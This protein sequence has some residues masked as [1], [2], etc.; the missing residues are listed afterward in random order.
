MY[1]TYVEEIA[2]PLSLIH[3]RWF[4]GLDY[5][6]QPW[7]MSYSHDQEFTYA[8]LPNTTTNP[9]AISEVDPS[10]EIKST[11]AEYERHA[12]DLYQNHGQNLMLNV[13][14][15]AVEKQKEFSGAAAEEFAQTFRV[16]TAKIVEAVEAREEKRKILPPQLLLPLK[17][18]K[19]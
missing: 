13:A 11:E 18:P 8:F 10:H 19:L 7:T 5:L 6:E 2:I 14:L 17:E 12:G 3:P 4:D 1:P 15:Q 9:S 16:Q